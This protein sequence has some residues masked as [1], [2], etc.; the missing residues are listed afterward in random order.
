[1]QGLGTQGK[2]SPVEVKRSSH[3][4]NLTP[5]AQNPH[6]Q[7]T[8]MVAMGSVTPSLG[9]AMQIRSEQGF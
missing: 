6:E 3:V 8:L 7:A 2:Q 5:K 4:Q 9:Q 1:M